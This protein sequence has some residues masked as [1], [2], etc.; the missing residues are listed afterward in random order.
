MSLKSIEN[1]ENSFSTKFMIQYKCLIPEMYVFTFVRK[2]HMHCWFY[3][4]TFKRGMFRVGGSCNLPILCAHFLCNSS[5]TIVHIYRLHMSEEFFNS[6]MT[7]VSSSYEWSKYSSILHWQLNRLHMNDRSIL[8]FFTVNCIVFIW[9]IE[10]FFNS[11]SSSYEWKVIKFFNDN[12]IVFKWV[13]N[14]SIFHW[15]LYRLHMNDGSILQFFTDNCIVFN[16]T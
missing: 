1:L 16:K 6:S 9:M 8:Q 15:Q 3:H 10:V 5:L 11:V 4:K 2:R 14:S 12:C 13:K 7:V